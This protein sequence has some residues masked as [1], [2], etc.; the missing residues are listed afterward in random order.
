MNTNLQ[1]TWNSWDSE[2]HESP[3]SQKRIKSAKN[4]KLTPIHLDTTDGYAYFQGGHGRYETFLDYCPC[5]DF[6]RRKLHCKHIYRLAMELG[7]FESDFA[8]D[9]SKIIVPKTSNGLSLSEAVEIVETLPK[10]SQHI[11]H[12]NLTAFLQGS[13]QTVEIADGYT[14]LLVSKGLL[15][16]SE[17]FNPSLLLSSLDRKKLFEKLEQTDIVFKKNISKAATVDIMLN[18]LSPDEIKD[19]FPEYVILTMTDQLS[20]CRK[21]LYSYIDRKFY[22]L[23]YDYSSE[24]FSS[25]DEIVALLKKYEPINTKTNTYKKLSYP[26]IFTPNEE[27]E[28]YTVVIPDLPGCV[29]EGKSLAEALEVATDAATN[30]II[31][32]E[33]GLYDI[34]EPSDPSTFNLEKDS[35][36]EPII[37]I[38]LNTEHL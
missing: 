22:P 13:Y 19:M 33:T 8:S 36:I 12:R 11:L 10:K 14:E 29:T 16:Y 21:N 34:P 26:A 30:W 28:G 5:G 25:N 2:I 23:K 18:N 15:R 37:L 35:F 17:V 7:L 24:Y 38:F 4:A 32:E 1:E 3:D 9:A 6:R 27:K 20:T 31:D